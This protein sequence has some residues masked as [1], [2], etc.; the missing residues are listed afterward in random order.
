MVFDNRI[1]VPSRFVVIEGI[2]VY[3][4]DWNG[5]GQRVFPYQRRELV[6]LFSIM[7]S[8]VV[9]QPDSCI[10]AWILECWLISIWCTSKSQ[11]LS[12]MAHKRWRDSVSSV[13]IIE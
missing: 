13:G 7:T 10:F 1:L 11:L 6:D 5:R 8:T 2:L 9:S 12:F 4:I 3:Q